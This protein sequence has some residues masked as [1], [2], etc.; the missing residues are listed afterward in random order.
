MPLPGNITTIIVTATITAIDGTPRSGYVLFDPGQPVT[1]QAGQAILDGP[2]CGRLGSNGVMAPVTL[3]AADSA[4]LN[5][6]G[7]AYTVTEVLDGPHGRTVGTPYQVQLLSAD[8]PTVDLSDLVPVNPPGP[9]ST[10]YGVLAQANTW[11][12]VNTFDEPVTLAGATMTG[13]I[14]PAVV[15][16]TDA[17][18]IAV[19]AELGNL[20]RVTLGGNR[21]LGNPTN[22]ADGQLIRVEVTQDATGSRLLSYGPAYDLGSAGAPALSTSAGA[23]DV[24]GFGFDAG[25]AK[26]RLLAFSSGY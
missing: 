20:F 7:F 10:I 6:A 17:A 23:M 19:N 13:W 18:T 21:T 3:P 22:G 1:D 24:L 4:H 26:W 9:V 5:P 25:A 11:T 15:T 16:L 2:A 8:A 14:A 12:G